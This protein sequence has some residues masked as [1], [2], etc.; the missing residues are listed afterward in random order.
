MARW[1]LTEPHY[2]NVPGTEWEQVTT[3]RVTQR[4]VRRKYPVPL[5]LDPR[6]QDDWN[7][8]SEGERPFR[9][10][11][12]DGSIIVCHEGKGKPND[13]VFVGDPTPGML[14]LD[15]EAK[16]I[17][18]KFKWIPTQRVD[19]G[20]GEAPASVQAEILNGLIKELA[21]ATVK[22]SS[23]TPHG[24]DKFMEAMAAMM[25]QQTQILQQL[26][27]KQ[28]EAEFVEQ[29]KGEAPPIEAEPLDE[30]EPPTEEEVAK[31]T[32]QAAA[33]DHASRIKAQAAAHAAFRRV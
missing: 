31:A 18:A 9:H 26:I 24:F 20:F 3:D 12:M 2:L 22:G 33:A 11:D 16:A 27:G 1:K 7:Y 8:D 28:Q 23:A 13:R 32:R 5:H 17:S 4:P 6:I 19:D 21:D 30:P 14:P 25:A 29:T 15:D 10:G